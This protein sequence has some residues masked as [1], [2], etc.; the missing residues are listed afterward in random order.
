MA[1]TLGLVTSILQLVDTALTAREYIEDF[2]HAPQEQQ[3]LLSEMDNLQP[4]L[5]ELRNRIEDNPTSRIIE[6]IQSPLSDFQSTMKQFTEK[7]R[8][9]AGLRS[10]FSKRLKWAMWSKTEA[11]EYL[12][13]F[14][15]FKSLLNSWLLL[16]LWDIG[17][18]NHREQ[19]GQQNALLRSVDNVASVVNLHQKTVTDIETEHQ[20]QLKSAER[21][22]IIEWLSPINFFLRH[23]DISQA[24]EPGT[25]E[26]LLA[27]PRFQH[28]KSSSGSTIWCHGIP[29]AGK[30][31]LASMVIDHLSANANIQNI[32]VAYVYLN[33]KESE[34]HT[35]AKVLSGLW[36]Q[37]VLDKD[38]S[39]VAKKIY[40]QHHEKKTSP[41]IKEVF[42]V[43]GSAVTGFSQVYIVVDA[44][45]EYPEAQR[46]ILC[47]YLGRMGSTV[48][49]MT[50]SRP[51]ITP[52]SFLP[53]L[54]TLEICA[55]KED[56]ERYVDA[57]IQISSRLSKHVQIRPDLQEQIHLGITCAVDGMFLLAKLHMDSLSSKSTIKGVR[58]ALKALPKTLYDSYENAM[59]RIKEQNE[60]CRQIAHST[61]TWV[62]NAK[63]P[64][65]PIE[66]QTALAVEPG[67]KSLDDEN[68]LDIEF[69]I[70]VCAGLVIVDEESSVVRLVHYT[71]QQYLDSIQ[72]QQFPDAQFEIAHILLTYL[73]FDQFCDW[74]EFQMCPLFKYSQYC[75][76]HAIGPPEQALR[77]LIMEFL[78]RSAEWIDCRSL[79]KWDC[80]PWDFDYWPSQCSPLWIAAA[81]NLVE[82]TKFLLGVLPVQQ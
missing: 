10:T 28:W 26:W 66:L 57:Q 40:Q 6:Q 47:E 30:T 74:A 19:S 50:T 24:R 11:K 46:R 82:T 51:H 55:S 52:E 38:I 43:L 75:L 42:D 22:Q 70:S 31:V 78:P 29:G 41:S 35:P 20:R 71:T 12:E 1:E 69:I 5:T 32:G 44:V 8:P 48:N 13:K 4:L 73:T 77:H 3:K 45:D 54:S 33:H 72:S 39:S 49:L 17:Q 2:R 65:T 27:D 14:E 68:I 62:A 80:S 76:A 67:A 21:T 18:Q 64:L 81:A 25:G 7:L 79:F 23:A 9:G 63:R 58:Q 56:I 34:G 16:N 59:D 61:L 53:N 15:Q 36:R 37:L 60:E